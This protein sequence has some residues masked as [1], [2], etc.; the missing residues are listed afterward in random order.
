[1]P[2]VRAAMSAGMWTIH[3]ADDGNS[4]YFNSSLNESVWH[5]PEGAEVYHPAP[6]PNLHSVYPVTLANNTVLKPVLDHTNE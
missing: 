5:L 6:H 4:F 3:Y 1:V 2:G